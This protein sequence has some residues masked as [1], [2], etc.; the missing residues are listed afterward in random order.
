[1]IFNIKPKPKYYDGDIRK[2]KSFCWL[3]TRVSNDIIWLENVIITQE[4]F[5]MYYEADHWIRWTNVSY[6]R[7]KQ[8]EN[9]K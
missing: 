1:M 3:P 4:A 9:Y 7:V 6:K 8:N 5:N 2:I